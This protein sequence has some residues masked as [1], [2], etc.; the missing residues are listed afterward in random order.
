[1]DDLSASVGSWD[2]LNGVDLGAES[3]VASYAHAV[4]VTG[5]VNEGMP[6]MM[7]P[8]IGPGG[9]VGPGGMMRPQPR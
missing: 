7:G 3:Q 9:M 1:M 2:V 4:E 5:F 8:M 6:A